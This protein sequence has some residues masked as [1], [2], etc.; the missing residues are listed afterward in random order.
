MDVVGFDAASN[1][2]GKASPEKE[3]QDD[4]LSVRQLEAHDSRYWQ[5]NNQEIR[6]YVNDCANQKMC[7]F[8]DTFLRAEA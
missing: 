1:T 7:R 4:T 2:D 6:E 3:G 5:D 8:V